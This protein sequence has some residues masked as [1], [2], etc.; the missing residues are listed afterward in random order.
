MT[1]FL[2][3]RK[4]F[5]ISKILKNGIDKYPA[6]SYNRYPKE[7]A[8]KLHEAIMEVECLLTIIR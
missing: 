5:P 4:K 1:F 3:M 7:L 8:L 2:G 6:S